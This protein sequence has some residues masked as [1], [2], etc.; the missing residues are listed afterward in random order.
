[1][2]AYIVEDKTINRVVSFLEQDRDS[3]HI[4]RKV[5]EC[6]KLSGF[7]PLAL[8]C[9]MFSLNVEGVEARYGDR[10]TYSEG[11]GSFRPLDYRYQYETCTRMQALKSLRCWLYQCSEG[12]I[13]ETSAFFQLMERYAGEL[14]YSIVADLPE[15]CAAAWG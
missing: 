4:K 9:A 8:G 12:D 5:G 1:M 14:A 11:D 3:A 2:S 15:Y 10:A 7:D 6:F 13:P